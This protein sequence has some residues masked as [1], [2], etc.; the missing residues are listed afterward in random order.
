MPTA[1]GA[2][3]KW[4]QI[5]RMEGKRTERGLGGYP[6]VTL[7]E[8]RQV[9]FENRRAVRRGENPWADKDAAKMVSVAPTPRTRCTPLSPCNEKRGAIPRSRRS[10]E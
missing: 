5:I 4:V 6:L 8:A 1:A 7:D 10:R 3:P 9:A 2:A